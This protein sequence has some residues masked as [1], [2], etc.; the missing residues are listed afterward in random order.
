LKRNAGKWLYLCG[1]GAELAWMSAWGTFIL[2]NC[3]NRA[4]PLAAILAAFTPA[5]F[6]T[7]IP[8]GRGWRVIQILG[9]H[10]IGFSLSG[11]WIV[12]LFYYRSD[13]L[14]SGGW[15]SDFFNR[16]RDPLEWF[17]L[18][19][20]L[21]YTLGL[22]IAGTLYE[23]QE[24]SYDTACTRFDRGLAAFLFLFLIKLILQSQ[25]TAQFKDSF[26]LYLV[27][28]FFI[29][30]LSEIGLTKKQED[31]PEKEFL[32]GFGPLVLIGFALGVLVL[33]TGLFLFFYPFLQSAS[34]V[35]Y[36]LIKTAATP[37][38]PII[39]AVLR[40]VFGYANLRSAAPTQKPRSVGEEPLI[41]GE[42][43]G[44]MSIV[45]K[46]IAWAG[47]GLLIIATIAAVCIALWFAIRWLFSRRPHEAKE[48]HRSGPNIFW[49]R[50]RLFI[51]T[52]LD[53][54]LRNGGR[55]TALQFY[56]LLLRWGKYSGLV[57]A[58]QET[59][60]EYGLR[61][62]RHFPRSKDEIRVIV[63]LFQQEIYGESTLPRQELET[64]RRAWKKLRNP[65]KWVFRLKTL[66]RPGRE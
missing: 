21:F 2:V 49:M 53:W 20:I 43:S 62:A 60:M 61:L 14:W 37:L 64:L 22:W 48:N 51:R 25:M 19:I 47:A 54:M 7:R 56:A 6:L 31:E 8:R 55:Q 24:K 59:P 34:L 4:F 57:H 50:I 16:P 29:F 33:G 44:W 46:V 15:I 32:S 42:T 41:A 18:V 52:L 58:P 12:H 13:P 40:F 1:A 11:L 63:E 35:G 10:L 65:S 17:L 36:D 26:T 39:V 3:F 5:A 28:P 66:L 27:F 9:L 23:L 45:E 38:G 30:G